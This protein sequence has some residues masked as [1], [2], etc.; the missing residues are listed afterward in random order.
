MAGKF[1]SEHAGAYA[2]V[3]AAG[4]PVTFRRSGVENYDAVADTST[5]PTTEV[6]GVA[7]DVKP[8][9]QE[10]RA[11]DWVINRTRTLFFVPDVYGQRPAQDMVVTLEGEDFQ[12]ASI[13]P[14]AP[15]GEMIFARIVVT[16]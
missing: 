10:Y 8:D 1:S 7:M 5:V 6:K 14:T 4:R 9:L 2:D 13:V 12:L 11:N 3:A 16:Q 15:D